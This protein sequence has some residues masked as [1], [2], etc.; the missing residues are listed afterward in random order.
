MI[1]IDKA[2]MD[3]LA[4]YAGTRALSEKLISNGDEKG[5][6]ALLDE[7]F[8]AMQ[9]KLVNEFLPLVEKLVSAGLISVSI[10]GQW[11]DGSVVFPGYVAGDATHCFPNGLICVHAAEV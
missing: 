10:D 9:S 11:G 7:D 3:T 1:R 4:R 2:T 8:D 5:G 6:F